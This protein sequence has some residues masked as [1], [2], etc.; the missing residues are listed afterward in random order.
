MG[1]LDIALPT[2]HVG[3]R[4]VAH[5]PAR[6]K[7]LACGRRW[8]K[9][10]LG[11]AL[12]V[13]VAL[14]RGR[15]WWIAPSYKMAQVGW[16]GLR[17]LA[18]QI[19]QTEVRLGEQMA[20]LPTGGT[21]Q[22]RSA[23]DPQSLRGEGLDYAVLDECAYMKAEA[24]N[25][26]LRPALS[27]RK[28]G[29]LFISTPHGL[30]WFRDLWQRGRD[31]AFPDWRA[32]SFKTADNPF[33]DAA[34]IAAARASMSSRIFM[35]EYEAS[36]LEDNPGA[37]WKRQWIDAGRVIQAP[38]LQRVVVGVDPSASS[39]GDACGIVV[40]GMARQGNDAALYVLDDA[41]LQGSPEAWA[42]A[43]VTAYHK[44]KA[45]S[46]IAEANQGGEMVTAV[47]RQVERNVPVKL[48]HATRGKAV[49]AEPVSAIYEQGRGHHVG[50]FALLEDE[51]CQW[52][53][54]NA[55]PNRL[56]ALVWAATELLGASS[57]PPASVLSEAVGLDYY[58]PERTTIWQKHGRR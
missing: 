25:E 17:L 53:Q 20:L 41:T 42:R 22:I 10:R 7:V 54:G 1:T 3:Q 15:A 12:C 57:T 52:E 30:N 55:S 56:D 44:H 33:I 39:G 46:I 2:L 4:E 21:V 19:P 49:R 11:T 26:A 24:W 36:F 6:F 14:Q 37:L 8:G 16:R 27:D 13:A 40:A 9:T 35:Q 29:A 45:D 23:D 5:D 48:V 50:E 32:W 18:A 34:E 58:K 51:L 28:G 47:L 38:D 31:A 43:A